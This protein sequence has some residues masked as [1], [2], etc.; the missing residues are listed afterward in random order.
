[1]R[2]HGGNLD[3]AMARHGGPRDAWIDLSTGINPRPYPIPDIA[4]H[5]WS[6]L[7]TGTELGAL[8][9]TAR[10]TYGWR[11]EV[12]PLAGAQAA[13]QIVPSL[14]APGTAH[15]LGPTYNEHAGALRSAGWQVTE[16]ATLAD[17]ADAD[18]AVLVN[19]NNPDGQRHPPSDLLALSREVGLLV[20]D[21]SFCD[22]EPGLSL[23]GTLNTDTDRVLIQRSFGKFYGL[24][25][26]RL[27]FALTGSALAG[28][29]R[30]LAGPWPVSGPAITIGCR[31]LAD[32]RWHAETVDRLTRDA[33]RLDG[34][35]KRAGWTLVGGTILFRTYMTPDAAA[36]Q[37]RLAQSR[38]WSRIFPYSGTWVRLGLPGTPDTWNRLEQA[39]SGDG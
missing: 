13:I 8:A 25:G 31:A 23:A 6:A 32:A 22:A 18:I 3:H 20:V 1:M 19:P 28:R 33:V 11:G 38:I 24:A 30:A 26:L 21:E 12:V 34:L 14:R 10:T 2:D 17:L 7:P 37:D 4:D 9:E 15:V 5:A 27:G 39:L 16:C 35:A 36:V 29:L